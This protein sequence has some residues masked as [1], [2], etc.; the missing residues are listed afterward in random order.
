MSKQEFEPKLAAIMDAV[1]E[2]EGLIYA[3][4]TGDVIVGQTLTE[5]D[6]KAI[7]QG[8]ATIL[9][10]TIGNPLKK[11]VLKDVVLTMENGFAIIATNGQHMVIGILGLD[12]KNSIGLLSRQLKL[13]NA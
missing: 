8:A 12:G 11:G 4:N 13:L 9:K 5:M 3:T 1:P 6:H 2:C 7:A 10:T